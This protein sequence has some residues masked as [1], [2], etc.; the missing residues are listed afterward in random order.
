MDFGFAESLLILGLLL[1]VAAVL[2]GVMRG[3]VLSVSVLSVGLG[4]SSGS[5]TWSTSTPTTRTC[6]TS[7]SWR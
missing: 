5:P 2:S 6:S 7:S 3:T 1:A 4:A